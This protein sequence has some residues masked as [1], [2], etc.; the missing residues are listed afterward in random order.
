MCVNQHLRRAHAAIQQASRTVKEIVKRKTTPDPSCITGLTPACVRQ[1]Y[2]IPANY[3][4][5]ANSGSFIGFGSFLNESAQE[6]DLLLFEKRYGFPNQTFD[7]VT[8]NN[9]VNNQS[10]P[11]GIYGDVG[12][13]NLDIQNII[14]VAH[15]LPV[16]EVSLPRS[17]YAAKPADMI[18][19]HYWRLSTVQT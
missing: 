10:E 1:L 13:A 15:G 3:T 5:P 11:T 9:G 12:E 2:N 18:I 7:V 19:V 16:R 6:S 14:G 8:I 17:E 4:P